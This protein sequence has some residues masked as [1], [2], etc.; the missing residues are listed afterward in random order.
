MISQA[1]P[2]GAIED[3]VMTLFAAPHIRLGHSDSRRRVLHFTPNWF[4]ATMG[5]GILAICLAQFPT[6]PTFFAA[7]EFL[8]L[9]NIALFACL[10]ALYVGKWIL[11]PREAMRAFAHPV[12]SM[13]FGCIP[14]GLAT[15]VNGM[16]IF[17]TKHFGDGAVTIA[18]FLWWL[19]A[20][21]AALSGLAI[22]FAMFTR[23]DHVLE[24]MSAVWL[25]PI[26][27]CEV[28]AASGGL[29]LPYIRE[30]SGQMSVLFTSYVLW[31]CSVPLALGL[32]TILFLRMALYKLPPADMASTAFLS[33]GPIGT[34]ALGLILF[35]VNGKGVL[36]ANDLGAFGEAM[37]G[38]ALL[39]GVLLWAY[40]LWWLG[41]AVAVTAHYLMK[42]LPFN[43]GW[44]GYTFP[45]GVYAVAT[46][47]LSATV[48]LQA[49][50]VFGDVL[51]AVLALIW[52][53][54]SVRTCLGAYDGTL[55]ADPSLAE[56]A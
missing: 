27:A 31:A 7:G 14:M 22:P 26:V 35:A 56:P 20:A 25:L 16:V 43:L 5:T 46:L 44:W 50:A 41:I 30:A 34:G 37:S 29:L 4:A 6:V 52:L 55:F 33:L 8:W 49:V 19:D 13:F 42:G 15:I 51:V 18:I 53:V 36:A 11:H 40:G 24:R 38:A 54:V 9:S 10:S 28:T 2:F 23:Q 17:G 1:Y 32:L 12:V 45:I 48:H 39:G 3:L 21:L 47:C